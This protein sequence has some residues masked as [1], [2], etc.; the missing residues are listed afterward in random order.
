M[1]KHHCCCDHDKDVSDTSKSI[2]EIGDMITRIFIP[3]G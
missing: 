2:D 3:F 1:S